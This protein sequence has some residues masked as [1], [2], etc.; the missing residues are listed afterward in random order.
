MACRMRIHPSLGASSLALLSLASLGAL[1][2]CS[3]KAEALSK[4]EPSDESFASMPA[5]P[6][7]G[8]KLAARAPLRVFALPSTSSK[9]LGEIGV[10][11]VVARSAGP[12]TNKACAAGWYAVRPHGF[13]CADAGVSLDARKPKSVADAALDRALPYRYGRARVDGVPL[14]AR[15][16][17]LAEQLEAEPELA[18]HPPKPLDQEVLGVAANDVPLDAHAVA[19]GPPVLL[20]TG[21]GVEG[22]KR[23]T[24]SFFTFTNTLEAP[25]TT[26]AIASPAK[27]GVLK[28]GTGVA[29][30]G[31]YV[32]EGPGDAASNHRAP[33]RFG[34]TPDGLL[35]PLD[36][37]RPALG[38]TWHGIDLEAVGLPIA[39]V[40]KQGVHT[41]GMQK[42]KAQ[43]RDDELER[44]TAVPLSGK[45]R[46]VEGVKYF[47]TREGEWMRAQDIVLVV[48]RTKF[49]DFARGKQRWI[50][51]SIANQTLTVY[52]GTRPLY[53]TLV[54]TGRDLLKDAATSAS[55]PRGNLR[56]TGKA[57]RKSLDAKEVAGAFD[58]L[59]APWA[60]D[61]EGGVTMA[62]SYF[63]DG[64][65]EA[66][67][68]HDILM[69]P[70][71]AHRVWSWA[72][73]GLPD[74]WSAAS[75]PGGEGTVVSVRP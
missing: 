8:P 15:V 74:G 12:V 63:G 9:E 48:K 16:P 57:V 47:E 39:F 56:V 69:T 3:G 31:A 19:S 34:V 49:P 70:I 46:T 55:T 52:E 54:S 59:D 37:L 13:V 5:P 33:R 27:I 20:P 36:R 23:T 7:G 65:G 35:A 62:G 11:G 64:V 17:T 75:D 44:K 25:T 4:V 58:P 53:A 66:S 72:E 21:D 38:S 42:G 29:L 67:T 10:G 60:L 28:K 43:K 2:G 6:E 50:D 24:L 45:F 26:F 41:F 22:G 68:F 30:A 1:A 14:Y 71:D 73:P 61:L 51:V 40:H 32:A 18:K